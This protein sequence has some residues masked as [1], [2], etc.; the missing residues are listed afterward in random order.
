MLRNMG[1]EFLI[2]GL[3]DLERLVTELKLRGL[4]L[5]SYKL[6]GDMPLFWE[7][8][9]I[10]DTPLGYSDVQNPGSYQ[11]IREEEGFFRHTQY[12]IKNILH[13]PVQEV[14]KIS[15]DFTVAQSMAEY[16]PTALFGVKPCDLASLKVLD[17]I[18]EGD[19]AYKARRNGVELIVVE[20]CVKPGG[21]CFCGSMGTGPAASGGYDLAYARL[22]SVV[23]F[24]VGSDRGLGIVENLKLS[25]A[26]DHV[27]NEYLKVMEEA[28]RESSKA[29]SIEEV[30]KALEK[31]VGLEELW[32]DLSARCVGCTNC[33]M[34]CPTCFCSE[35]VDYVKLSGEANRARQ[36]FGCLSYT[37]GQIAGMHYRPELFMRYRHFILHKFLFYQKQV[38]LPG[39]VGCGRCITWC[40]MGIDL[41]EVISRVVNYVG[42]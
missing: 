16:S 27:V 19:D 38:G 34:V 18:L 29:P 42:R 33:N 24:K 32:R 35:F 11:L 41:R 12:S 23:V 25:P 10:Q 2:G 4:K 28:R 40:P 7:I 9:S 8:D 6:R 17:R 20:E 30:S 37:Y 26:P 14:L 36:W 3:K 5:L 31:A 15:E 13:P 1:T 21:T 39:C 22:G